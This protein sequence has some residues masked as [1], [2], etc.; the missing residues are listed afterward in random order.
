[1]RFIGVL[2]TLAIIGYLF[3]ILLGPG[4]KPLGS[5]GKTAVQV[6]SSFQTSTGLPPSTKKTAAGVTIERAR[7]AAKVADDR[8]M[9]MN[10][11]IERPGAKP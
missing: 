3:Y 11:L 4:P 5:S 1:M 10:D 2:L 7:Q 6:D 8:T 9:L